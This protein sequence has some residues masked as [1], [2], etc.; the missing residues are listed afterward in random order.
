[1][2]AASLAVFSTDW[3]VSTVDLASLAAFSAVVTWPWA[4]AI[5]SGLAS[6]A[7]VCAF[8]KLASAVAR[9]AWAW[10]AAASWLATTDSCCDTAWFAALACSLAASTCAWVGTACVAVDD[11]D[12]VVEAWSFVVTSSALAIEDDIATVVIPAA[13]KNFFF[14]KNKLLN[15]LKIPLHINIFIRTIQVSLFFIK[16]LILTK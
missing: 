1:M 13:T 15:I 11:T 4:A 10:F 2:S 12:A 3:A 8:C 16:I 6:S 5:V 9:F 14:I 7:A